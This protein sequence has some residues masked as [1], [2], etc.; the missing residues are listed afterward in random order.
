MRRNYFAI[1][2]KCT[3]LIALVECVYYSI[4]RLP[5]CLLDLFL[6]HACQLQVMQW[7]SF[8]IT[9]PL[10]LL[11]VVVFSAIHSG[12]SRSLQFQM[13]GGNMYYSS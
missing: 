4:R 1:V 10:L 13:D 5:Y 2:I 6:A 11:G 12:A 3:F 8:N 7:R 9:A